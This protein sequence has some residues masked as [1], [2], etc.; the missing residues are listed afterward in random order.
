M[1]EDQLSNDVLK[2]AFKVH[3]KLGPGLL[4]KVYQVCLA[5]ELR[6]AGWLVEEEVYVPI[7]YDGLQFERG[8]RIDLLV[9]EEFIVELK[10]VDRI[11]DNH[12]AQLLTYL[13]FSRADRG[14]VLN[15][16]ERSLKDGIRR[17]SLFQVLTGAQ[18]LYRKLRETLCSLSATL[19]S[20]KLS[21]ASG[22]SS[23]L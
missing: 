9:Q 1:I 15:F 14:L 21:R 20:R 19:C 16:K 7:V 5:H 23:E 22:P 10:V 8:Y 11:L 17:V 6:N 2:C 4:E 3:A 13:K 18:R 12:I